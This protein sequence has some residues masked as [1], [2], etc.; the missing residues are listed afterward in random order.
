MQKFKKQMEIYKTDVLIIGGGA[1]GIR[2]AVAAKES[3]AK[4]LLVTND[5]IAADGSTYSNISQGWGIQAL[6]GGERDEADIEKFCR[7]ILKAGAGQCDPELVRILVEES[8]PRIEDLLRM[9][10][11]LKRP[12]MVISCGLQVVSAKKNGHF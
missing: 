6:V 5:Q 12:Q 1:A 11:A 9:E 3:N 4:A 7:E 2:A 10:C 8:G